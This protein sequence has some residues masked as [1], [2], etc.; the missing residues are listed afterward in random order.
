MK[1]NAY[2]PIGTKENHSD[3]LVSTGDILQLV[4]GEK[5][6]FIA[7]RRS[8]FEAKING[9]GLI[10]PMY[11][12]RMGSI[13][14]VTEIVGIDKTALLKTIKPSTLKL[15]D[16]FY[17]AGH[18]ETFLFK[19]NFNRS[20]KLKVKALDLASN[21]TFTIDANMDLVKINLAASKKHLATI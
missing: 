1:T 5:V 17:I 14:F 16:L 20:G 10:V 18:K 15:G 9:R 7:M 19:E 12:D 4:T 8:K 2:L 11:R 21:K 13:P 6:V 3:K